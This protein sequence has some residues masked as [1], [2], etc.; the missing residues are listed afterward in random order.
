MRL[1]CLRSRDIWPSSRQVPV[2]A[3]ILFSPPLFAFV[4]GEPWRI[5][6]DYARIL[7]FPLAV[8]FVVSPLAVIMPATGNIRVGSIWKTVY[9]VT[10]WAT[11]GIACHFR[12]KTF[13]YVYS[14][15]DSVL[16]ACYFL[17]IL[18]ASVAGRVVR[19]SAMDASN[20][21]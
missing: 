9:F 12:P 16:Y 10:T 7:A 21:L 2:L 13:L 18:K 14:I 20:A 6:G 3:A 8:K 1:T 17:L 15:H 11:L 5:A 4:F 19:E